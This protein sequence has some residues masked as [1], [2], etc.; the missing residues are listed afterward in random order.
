MIFQLIF[1]LMFLLTEQS[2]E[3]LW[4]RP[5]VQTK[6]WR[7]VQSK[8][9]SWL[10][11]FDSKKLNAITVLSLSKDVS[12][13][14]T[15]NTIR[16]LQ[17]NLYSTWKRCDPLA[18]NPQRKVAIQSSISRPFSCLRLNAR[19]DSLLSYLEI[20]KSKFHPKTWNQ[21]G[22]KSAEREWKKVGWDNR[23][24]AA[25]VEGKS[26]RRCLLLFL[27]HRS[28]LSKEGVGQGSNLSFSHESHL[29]TGG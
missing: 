28:S 17:S 11:A 21:A 9:V 25:Q 6:L 18:E 3:S 14:T 13:R 27:E 23:S 19:L 5:A 1:G 10:F 8:K 4:T 7:I 22:T 29:S 12:L 16:N 2:S 24:C 15:M 20:R 26:Y